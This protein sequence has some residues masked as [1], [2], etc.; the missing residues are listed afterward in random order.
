MD[1]LMIIGRILFGGYFLYS[2]INGHFLKNAMFSQYAGSKGVPMPKLAV[3]GSGLL[4]L[5][6]GLGVIWGNTDYLNYSLWLIVIFLVPVTLKM[7]AFW[8]DTDPMLKMMNQTNFLKN[9]ALL[10]AALSMMS[11]Y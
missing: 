10:G 7:H 8:N 3:Y 6:G 5:L 11:G 1:I 9:L 4:I 2:A